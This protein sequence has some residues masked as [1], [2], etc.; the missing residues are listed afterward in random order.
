MASGVRRTGFTLIEIMI[1]VAIVGILAAIAIPNMMKYQARSKQTEART[2][3]KAYFAIQKTYFAEKDSYSSNLAT[4]GFAPER[5]NRYTY[6]TAL[7]P[8]GWITRSAAVDPA[9]ADA[10]G[11]EVDCFKFSGGGCIARPPRPAG[12]ATFAVVYPE[13]A[14]GPPDT[15]VVSGPF[16]GYIMEARGSVDNDPEADVWMVSSGTLTVTGNMCADQQGGVAGMPVQLFNDVSC[17]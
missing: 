3:L 15:G 1:V 10:Q 17:P 5:G 12:V 11:L 7:G 16:G 13:A 2:N 14:S 6:Q 8:T 4:L 9:V